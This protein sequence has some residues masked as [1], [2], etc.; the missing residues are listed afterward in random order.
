MILAAVGSI[1]NV[2]LTGD[3]NIDTIIYADLD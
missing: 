2:A 3:I 1:F